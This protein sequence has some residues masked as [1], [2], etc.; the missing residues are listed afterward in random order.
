[1]T[2]TGWIK[3]HRK[4]KY[5]AVF[6]MPPLHYKAWQW[7]KMTADYKTGKVKTSL[8]MMAEAIGWKERNLFKVPNK[9][10]MREILSKFESNGMIALE[11]NAQYTE[12]TIINW[13][14]YQ[15]TEH[16]KVTVDGSVKVT[17]DGLPSGLPSGLPPIY[18]D[19]AR[20]KLKEVQEVQPNKQ[21]DSKESLAQ[22]PLVEKQKKDNRNPDIK[23]VIQHWK[24]KIR[25]DSVFDKKARFQISNCLKAKAFN[26]E[27]TTGLDTTLLAIDNFSKH[28]KTD[29]WA[30]INLSHKNPLW[31]FQISRVDEY[32]HKKFDAP[33]PS[34]TGQ[35]ADKA[36]DVSQS[37]Y[38]EWTGHAR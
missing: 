8:G 28:I 23:A 27:S 11:S 15:N 33:P 35:H 2:N 10:T 12:I 25:H 34:S 38:K 18:N 17:P 4:E 37:I 6:E 21:E 7:L 32:R 19:R 1:M 3:Q 20:K 5:S 16:A 36:P 22:A 30:S 9:K 29:H 24:E 14:A 13:D 31:F 26:S